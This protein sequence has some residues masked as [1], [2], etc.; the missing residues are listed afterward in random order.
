MIWHPESKIFFNDSIINYSNVH[1]IINNNKL[2]EPWVREIFNFLKKFL[3]NSKTIEIESSGSTGESKKLTIDKVKMVYSANSSGAYFGLNPGDFALLPLS[4][5]YIAGKMMLVRAII[6]GLSLRIVKPSS[7]PFL[8]NN[9]IENYDFASFVPLQLTSILNNELTKH[10]PEQINQIIVGGTSIDSGLLGKIRKMKNQ[11]F[12]TFGMT[13]TLTHVAVRRLNLTE[14]T[15]SPFRALPGIKFSV[16]NR[17][18]LV[19]KSKELLDS[20]L[21]TNDVVNLIN[22]ETFYWNGRIDNVINT[23]GIKIFPEILERQLEP[24]ITD[25]F[26]ISSLPHETLGRQI[27]LI[28]EQTNQHSLYDLVWNKI[29]EVLPKYSRPKKI[30]FIQE[31]SRNKHGKIV[32][33]QIVDY[34]ISNN[35][36]PYKTL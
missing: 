27:I 22:D 15:N 23:G 30:Y 12:E 34:I 18:C 28:I 1:E 13:E 4:L 35:I 29:F 19:I 9:V 25:N 14:T 17:N 11:V 36:K 2:N 33:K 24:F 26:C 32:R 5:T 21:I 8:D 3:N 10:Q 31:F 16:D 7:N 20:D 6:L